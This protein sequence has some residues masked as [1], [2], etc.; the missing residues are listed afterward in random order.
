MACRY[1]S[2]VKPP[3]SFKVFRHDTSEARLRGQ[4][5]IRVLASL[6]EIQIYPRFE[7]SLHA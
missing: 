6:Q 1:I 4:T 3:H 5:G 2:R 7:S